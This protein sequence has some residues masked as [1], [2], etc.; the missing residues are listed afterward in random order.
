MAFLQD[1]SKT[2]KKNVH[3]NGSIDKRRG[4]TREEETTII[5]EANF[6]N[7]LKRHNEQ[8]LEYVIR[9]YGGY[10]KAVLVKNL[11]GLPQ[12][13]EECMDDVFLDVWEHIDRFDASKGSFLNWIIAIARFRSID[14]LRRYC[15]R[16]M[17][18]DVSDYESTLA[19]NDRIDALEQEISTETEQLLE[20]LKEEER[21][22]LLRYYAAEDD[23]DVLA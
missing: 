16:C 11:S 12:E 7:K 8:A 20:G 22:I 4:N 3:T 5:T 17:E 13:M 18:E 15:R 10:V 14:Y 19:K 21:Q 9:T 1:F 6:L 2:C 23:V